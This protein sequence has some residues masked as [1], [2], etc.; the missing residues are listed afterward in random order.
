ML[1][2]DLAALLLF[3]GTSLIVESV[4]EVTT[5]TEI[6]MRISEVMLNRG[7]QLYL[8]IWPWDNCQRISYYV[9]NH[10]WIR[11]LG[12][13]SLSFQFVVLIFKCQTIL[14]FKFWKTNYRI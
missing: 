7:W 1:K 2:S 14:P 4:E 12:F 13:A 10:A 5:V 6:L 11:N 8:G 3:S 9:L